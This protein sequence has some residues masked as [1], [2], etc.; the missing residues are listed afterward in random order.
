MPPH[1][2]P[3]PMKKWSR[4]PSDD[5]GKRSRQ[6]AAEDS[7]S[8]IQIACIGAAHTAHFV[9]GPPEPYLN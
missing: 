1:W 6:V 5:D 8:H 3:R 7:S 4:S 2:P 9:A